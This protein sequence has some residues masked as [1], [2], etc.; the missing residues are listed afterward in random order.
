MAVSGAVATV[1][2]GIVAVIVTFV[3]YRL[4]QNRKE[5]LTYE[6]VSATPVVSVAKPYAG[7][8]KVL[9]DD[10]PMSDVSLVVVRLTNTGNKEILAVDFEGPVTVTFFWNR[11][12]CSPWRSMRRRRPVLNRALR[13]D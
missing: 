8:I 9:W 7:R 6:I 13:I 10:K 4:Q 11:S 3:I 12:G 5:Y 2:F 1:V